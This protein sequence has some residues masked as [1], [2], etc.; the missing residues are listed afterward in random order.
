MARFVAVFHTWHV[1]S[2]GFNAHNL[3]ST[4]KESAFAEAAAIKCKSYDEGFYSSD[5]TLV[6]LVDGEAIASL[7]KLTL[8][9]RL[10]GFVRST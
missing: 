6:E 8:K 1:K 7:R 9:E 4:D 10:L 2:K 5:F 3:T